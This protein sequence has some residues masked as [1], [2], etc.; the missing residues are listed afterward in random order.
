M[1]TRTPRKVRFLVVSGG[2]KEVGAKKAADCLEEGIRRVFPEQCAYICKLRVHDAGLG[3]C[4]A[5]VAAHDGQLR[6]TTVLRN[7]IVFPSHYGLID[8]G[9]TA[10]FD[11]EATV[12][13]K[14]IPFHSLD[15]TKMTS[16]G[17]GRRI[18]HALDSGC[19]KIVVGCGDLARCDGGAGML[20]ALGAKLLDV[21]GR[22]LPIAGGASS[23]SLLGSIDMSSIHSKLRQPGSFKRLFVRFGM[24]Y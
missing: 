14:F 9:K 5:V 16:Y 4:R 2:F 18:V 8:N 15:L 21:D 22:E 12:G 1:D 11:V 3:F 13:F 23:L 7:G 19:T 20:Q 6:K 10:I 24:L 17:I